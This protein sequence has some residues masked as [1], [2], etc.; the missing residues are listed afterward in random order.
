MRL[1]GE[2]K[3][4]KHVD[5]DENQGGRRIMKVGDLNQSTQLTLRQ[6]GRWMKPGAP[7]AQGKKKAKQGKYSEHT[8]KTEDSQRMKS[9]RRTGKSTR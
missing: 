2:G 3:M 6:R 9:G 1:S 5:Q 7:V 8:S 4:R